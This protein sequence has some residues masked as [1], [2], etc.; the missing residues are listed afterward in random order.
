MPPLKHRSISS[1]AR[2]LA[3]LVH[4]IESDD[5]TLNAPYQRGDVWTVDQRINLI[6]SILMGIPIAAVVLN[7]RGDNAAWERD[8]GPVKFGQPYF[9]CIDGKQRLTTVWMWMS[10]EFL[11]PAEWFAPEELVVEDPWVAFDGLSV[12]RQRFF[13]NQAILPVAEATLGSVAEEAEV[14]DL[15]NSAGTAHTD[16]DLER[17]RRVAR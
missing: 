11:V 9:A 3:D 16:V 4:S 2:S 10:S 15:I 13:R 12:V 14:Y 8:S 6:K 17:A 7:R 1:S 5:L